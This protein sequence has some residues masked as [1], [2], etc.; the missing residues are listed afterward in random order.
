MFEIAST[1]AA[2]VNFHTG[3]RYGAFWSFHRRTIR[4]LQ[5]Y[6]QA[7]GLCAKVSGKG[8]RHHVIMPQAIPRPCFQVATRKK[9]PSR[10][11]SA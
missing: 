4:V 7:A 2:G 9:L 11:V 8:P 5:L 3:P 1:G 6:P 10:R